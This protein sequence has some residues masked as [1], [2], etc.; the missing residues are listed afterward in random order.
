MKDESDS[1]APVMG[2]REAEILDFIGSEQLEAFTFDG[3]RRGLSIHP[4]TLSRALDRLE[5][6]GVVRKTSEGYAVMEERGGVV[7]AAHEGETVQLLQTLLPAGF[8]PESLLPR[9]NGSWFG[10]LRWLGLSRTRDELALNWITES[11]GVMVKAR[12]LA[13]T[14]MVEARLRGSSG[15]DEAVR[16]SYELVGH[17]SR[18][19]V[20]PGRR[21]FAFEI[22][23]GLAS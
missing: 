10:S 23:P 9:L 12:F 8:K 5:E 21:V 2:G 19:F 6:G 22:S 11:G 16:A 13:G 15:L 4:E 1:K 3:L 14:L 17:L 7:R 18:L 20:K